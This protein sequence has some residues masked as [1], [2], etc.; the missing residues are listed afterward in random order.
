MWYIVG[1][2]SKFRFWSDLWFADCPLKS[3][4]HCLKNFQGGKNITH[5][6]LFVAYVSFSWKFDLLK[7]LNNKEYEVLVSLPFDRGLI[8]HM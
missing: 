5:S 4:L 3:S 6:D 8:Y 1:D 7:N 2:R